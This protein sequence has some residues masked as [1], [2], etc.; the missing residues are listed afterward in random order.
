MPDLGFMLEDE[1]WAVEFERVTKSEERLRG[2]LR[3]YRSAELAGEVE[4]V[5]YVCADKAIVRRVQS[6][7]A[8]VELDRAVRTLDWVIAEVRSRRNGHE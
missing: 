7:A 6:I 2:I 1:R 4:S 5:L 3:A 8:E